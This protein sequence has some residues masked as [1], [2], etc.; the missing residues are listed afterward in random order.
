M[1]DDLASPDHL[2]SWA[3][4]SAHRDLPPRR[5][6]IYAWYFD[7]VPATVPT[8]R[9]SS[10]MGCT[11]LYVGIAPKAGP[12]AATLRSRVHYHFRGNAEGST[13]RPT[14]GCLLAQELG[15]ELRRVGSGRRMTFTKLGEDGLTTWMSKRFAQRPSVR[16]RGR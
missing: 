15:L 10:T 4:I 9:C 13:L 5:A 16:L 2:Y 12:S 11:L 6:G 3:E 7:R 8:E 14:L 1:A